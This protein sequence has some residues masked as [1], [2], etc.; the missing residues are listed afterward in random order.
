M[1]RRWRESVSQRLYC[2]R[3]TV[4]SRTTVSACCAG[5]SMDWESEGMLW[6]RGVSIS[7]PRQGTESE[8]SPAFD[9]CRRRCSWTSEPGP[10]SVVHKTV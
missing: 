10:C 8:S 3:E 4:R 2:L 6:E 7:K 9:S 1:T 5:S